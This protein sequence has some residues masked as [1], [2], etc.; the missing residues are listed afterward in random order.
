MKIV[1][2]GNCEILFDSPNSLFQ[3]LSR[4]QK[5][6]M[7]KKIVC[8]KYKKGEII[9]N[10][11]EEPAG[12]VCLTQ[13]KV[14]LFKKGVGGK[15]HIVRL[16]RPNGLLGYRAIFAAEKSQATA[17][18]MEESI[19]C[20]LDKDYLFNMLE[21]NGKLAL[22]FVKV[23][24]KELG[25]VYSRTITLTQKHIRGRLAET[26]MFLLDFYGFEEDGQ[27]IKAI[28]LREDLAKLSNMTTS[29][30]I[31]TLSAFA[32]EGL[33]ELKGKKIKLLKLVDL[34]K[35]STQG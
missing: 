18:A 31:R 28:L 21:N 30:A 13:G 23:L 26:L 2:D 34:E 4:E 5:D 11:G 19:I 16:A 1:E 15:E 25:F 35:I 7:M 3:A 22:S 8:S 29:N 9:F 24:A 33:L 10:E 20:V 12:L 14:K 32:N 6:E 17:V 27:T